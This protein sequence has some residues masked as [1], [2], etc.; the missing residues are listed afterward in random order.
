MN[1]TYLVNGSCELKCIGKTIHFNYP[2]Y[3]SSKNQASYYC[4]E[5]IKEYFKTDEYL[6]PTFIQIIG[7]AS[8]YNRMRETLSRK[9]QPYLYRG[10]DVPADVRVP[11]KADGSIMY[12]EDED[13]LKRMAEIKNKPKMT[14]QECMERY[15]MSLK[16]YESL[17]F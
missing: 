10:K 8:T 12:K 5:H 2:V 3:A 13:F 16:E 11:C 1:K 17:P 14:E 15:G 9:F 6:S 4:I 7:M